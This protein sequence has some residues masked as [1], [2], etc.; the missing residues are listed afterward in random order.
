[1]HVT[2]IESSTATRRVTTRRVVG[3]PGG[4]ILRTPVGVRWPPPAAGTQ[5]ACGRK[6]WGARLAPTYEAANTTVWEV[7][8]PGP[9]GL[10]DEAR[11]ERSICG[12]VSS[13]SVPPTT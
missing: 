3:W 1:L 10:P 4:V 2:T 7:V 6:V 12:S 11:N 5:P 9:T 8:T 13:A